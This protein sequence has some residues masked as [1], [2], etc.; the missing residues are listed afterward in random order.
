MIPKQEYSYNICVNQ[1]QHI[2]IEAIQQCENSFLQLN[3]E[4]Y[5]SG[6]FNARKIF[7]SKREEPKAQSFFGQ[8][9]ES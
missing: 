7:F 9:G 4:E 3:N 8:R 2:R 1:Q 5:K 6:V